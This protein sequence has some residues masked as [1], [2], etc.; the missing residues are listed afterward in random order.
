VMVDRHHATPLA[1][2]HDLGIVQ[3]FVGHTPWL[4]VRTPRATPWWL[5]PFAIHMPQGS[6][7][8]R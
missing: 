3:L 7:V 2:F 5:V 4:G 8:F 1:R 6:A